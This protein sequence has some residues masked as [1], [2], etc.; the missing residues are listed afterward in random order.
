MVLNFELERELLGFGAGVKVLSPRLLA[1]RIASTLQQAAQLYEAPKV[2]RSL[3]KKTLIYATCPPQ[4][5]PAPAV[6]P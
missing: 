5:D 2:I 3:D 4:L 6:Q 1:K